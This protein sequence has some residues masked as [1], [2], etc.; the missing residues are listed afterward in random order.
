[1]NTALSPNAIGSRKHQLEAEQARAVWGLVGSRCDQILS[2]ALAIAGSEPRRSVSGTQLPRA[3]VK[4]V[5]NY[6][7]VETLDDLFDRRLMLLFEPTITEA[8]VGEL[9]S[10]LVEA[11]R[12]SA[13]AQHSA[14]TATLERLQRDHGLRFAPPTA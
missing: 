10:C 12:L 7:W 9:A 6:E 13:D 14:T 3:F 11:G 2:D 1:M 5:I 8:T 4:W